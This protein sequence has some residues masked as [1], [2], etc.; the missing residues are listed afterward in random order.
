MPVRTDNTDY[1]IDFLDK[2][3]SDL[4]LDEFGGRKVGSFGKEFYVHRR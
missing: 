4:C 2:I 1:P 3:Y